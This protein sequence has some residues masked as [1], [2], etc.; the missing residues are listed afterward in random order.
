MWISH[1][2]QIPQSLSDNLSLKVESPSLLCQE[3]KHLGLRH[4]DRHSSSTQSWSKSHPEGT[5]VG[6]TN[7]QDQCISSE[8]GI[9][10]SLISLRLCLD[11]MLGEGKENENGKVRG[12]WIVYPFY[13]CFLS[14]TK[15]GIQ[16]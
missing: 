10:S 14:L 9:D 12:S 6:A 15:S 16:T 11:L 4:Q 2:Q 1:E 13:V 5:V 3:A 8:S 7:S